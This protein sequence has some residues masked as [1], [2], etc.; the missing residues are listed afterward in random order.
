MKRVC[1]L[2]IVSLLLIIGVVNAEKKE[3]NKVEL[4]NGYR[5]AKDL[6]NKLFHLPILRYLIQFD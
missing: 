3:Y 5:Y 2:L 1:L 4:R 6:L